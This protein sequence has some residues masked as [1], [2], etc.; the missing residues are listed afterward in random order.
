[1]KKI[2]S[3][4]F[5]VL[6]AAATLSAQQ[7]AALERKVLEIQRDPAFRHGT[8]SVCVYNVSKGRQVY[9]YNE[10]MSMPPAS[11]MKLF[12]TGTGFARLGSDFRFTTQLA[13]RGEIDRDGRNTDSYPKSIYRS[14]TNIEPLSLTFLPPESL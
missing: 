10:Q 7:S 13:I 11:V 4:F 8:L 5:I 1:M 3:L 14:A 6:F 2:S 12:T 9:A